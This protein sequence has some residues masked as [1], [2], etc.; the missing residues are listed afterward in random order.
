MAD[1][2]MRTN[3]ARANM[4]GSRQRCVHRCPGRCAA[5]KST[6][7]QPC[8]AC[9]RRKRF[10]VGMQEGRGPGIQYSPRLVMPP[11]IIRLFMSGSTEGCATLDAT[12]CGAPEVIENF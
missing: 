6:V 11:P 9:M 2:Y 10:A 1:P 7:L 4:N 12:S 3:C 5:E 8:F